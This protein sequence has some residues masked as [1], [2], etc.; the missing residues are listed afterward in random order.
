MSEYNKG[1]VMTFGDA[2][3]IFLQ[4]LRDGLSQEDM[5]ALVATMATAP[6]IMNEATDNWEAFGAHLL[7]KLSDKFGDD[8]VNVEVPDV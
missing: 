5:M 6:A 2:L 1:E 4:G 3:Y 8:R 7:S